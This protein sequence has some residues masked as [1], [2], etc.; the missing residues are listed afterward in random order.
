[1][2]LYEIMFIL[3]GSLSENETSKLC[4]TLVAP[5]SKEKNFKLQ[6]LGLKQLAYPIK[7]NTNG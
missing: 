4:K 2:A 7:K 5:F 6:E 3:S 1:M